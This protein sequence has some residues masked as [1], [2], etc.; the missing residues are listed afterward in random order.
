MPQAVGMIETSSIA[1]GHEAE[2]A[3]LKAADVRLLVARTI[4]SGKYLVIIGGDVAAVEAALAAGRAAAE[5]VLIDEMIVP[6]A[7]PGVFPALA[8]SVALPAEQVGALGIVETFSACS[9]VE[10]AD[11]AAKAAEVT[12]LRIHVAMAIGGKGFFLCTGDVAAVRSAIEAG[13]AVAARHGILVAT[14]V[15]P[16]PQRELFRE[17]I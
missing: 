4:C 12:L 10:A 7:H 17:Y 15:I 1:I 16:N 11:A 14:A 9:I 13:A 5:G 2:D 8:N 6:V 3:M